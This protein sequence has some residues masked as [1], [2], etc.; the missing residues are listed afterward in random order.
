MHTRMDSCACASVHATLCMRACMCICVYLR[1]SCAPAYKRAWGGGLR[2]FVF[3][4]QICGRMVVYLFTLILVA[5]FVCGFFLLRSLFFMIF[6]FCNIVTALGE[7]EDEIFRKRR[8]DDV[9]SGGQIHTKTSSGHHSMCL[10]LPCKLTHSS[11]HTHTHSHARTHT[12][13]RTLTHMHARIHTHTQTR[14]H[15]HTH[16][17]ICISAYC[18][19]CVH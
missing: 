15:T 3:L 9:R 6:F 5:L 14:A 10:T 7:V 1:M 13:T 18:I 11:T 2:L 19:D 4:I 8:D 17:H 16:T 12:H